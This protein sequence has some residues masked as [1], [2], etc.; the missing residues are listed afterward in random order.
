VDYVL[1]G[2]EH[3]PPDTVLVLEP[4]RPFV[5]AFLAGLNHEM[6]R[7]LLWREYPAGP[8]VTCFQVFWDRRGQVPA[9]TSLD[10]IADV[11]PV[12]AWDQAGD[13][14][15]VV[16]R[17]PAG[18]LVLVV[19]SELLRR[20]PRAVVFA[21]KAVASSPRRAVS[22]DTVAAN[23]KLPRFAGFIEPD[24]SFFG[25]GLG[26]AQARGDDDGLGWY[27][28]FQEQPSEPRFGLD[29]AAAGWLAD[30]PSQ[31]VP[32]TQEDRPALPTAELAWGHLVDEQRLA[33]LAHAPVES[34]RP[35]G[36]WFPDRPELS[37]TGESAD[38]AAL[39]LQ[40]PARVA[41]H[42]EVLLPKRPAP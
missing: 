22:D 41:I 38:L 13:L 25:F 31:R 24:I 27:F 30:P 29:E 10:E 20:F 21:A 23:R 6:Q 37:W 28:V 16:R 5:A 33:T 17:D 3:I 1:P 42:A 15:Q 26:E 9:G 11:P 4:N 12:D 40:R 19:R 35:A 2:T 14:G 34:A 18:E 39:T 7:E 36:W 32:G 8:A